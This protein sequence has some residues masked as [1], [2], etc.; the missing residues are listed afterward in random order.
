MRSILATTLLVIVGAAC[1]SAGT[2]A[3]PPDHATVVR[4]IDGDT[5]VVDLGGDE[6][7]VRLIGID[8]PE[9]T[10]GFQPPECYG[11]E[12]SALTRSLLPPDTPIRLERDV[13]AR[14]RFDRLLAY[15][16]RSDDDLFVNMQLAEAGAAG[17]LSIAPNTTYQ[18]EFS[19]A[20]DRARG[21]ALGLWG[22]CDGPDDVVG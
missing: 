18:S 17:P 8:T 2:D 16:Y 10:G 5:I 22:A 20:A 9:P 3:R 14:D 15:V 6:V 4:V 19:A 11:D 12:A 1:G 7:D 13:E 21:A